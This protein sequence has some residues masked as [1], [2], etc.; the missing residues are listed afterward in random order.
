MLNGILYPS[1][2]KVYNG[3]KVRNQTQKPPKKHPVI[4]DIDIID[5]ERSDDTLL[6]DEEEKEYLQE[7]ALDNNPGRKGFHF[8][9]HIALLV[10]VVLVVSIVVYRLNHW[11]TFISQDDIFVDGEGIYEAEIL[12]SIFPAEDEDGNILPPDHDGNG[13]TILAFGNAPFADDAGSEDSLASMMEDLT[14]GTVIN[15]AVSGSYAASEWPYLSPDDVPMDAYTPYWLCTLAM[16]SEVAPNFLKVA[17]VMGDD[18]PPEG[19]YVYET[20]SNIDLNTID[21]ITFMYDATDY[22]M[23]HPMYNDEDPTDIR[24]FTGNIEAA[25]GML[26]ANYPH[27]RIIILSPTYAFAVDDD[28]EY[29]SSDVKRYDYDVLSTYSIRLCYSCNTRRVTFVDNLYGTITED[30]ATEY[31]TDNLHLNVAGRRLVAK[32]FLDALTYYGT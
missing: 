18:L 20:L 5:L 6:A 32:R 28:G 4:P 30:N 29:I 23:N 2:R 25:L 16:N 15:C 17:E 9:M 21:V 11:G 27:L 10:V 26:Q 13:L 7:E 1:E 8:Y 31:L 14:G 19:E 3:E 24:Q 12:D 22:L